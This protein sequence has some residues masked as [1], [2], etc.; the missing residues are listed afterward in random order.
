MLA[1][2]PRIPVSRITFS[3]FVISVL[4]FARKSAGVPLTISNPVS[5]SF[6]GI[7]GRVSAVG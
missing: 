7:P 5:S 4:I 2:P 3:H 1:A 6:S